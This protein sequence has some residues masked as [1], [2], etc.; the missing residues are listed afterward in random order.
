MTIEELY[1]ELSDKDP[2]VRALAVQAMGKLGGSEEADL[3]IE[4]MLG[5]L[6]DP[7]RHVI[8]AASDA[9]TEFCSDTLSLEACQKPDLLVGVTGGKLS[10]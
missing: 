3:L 9:L 5:M 8:W 6:D 4:R 7:E 1:K 2:S 10:W